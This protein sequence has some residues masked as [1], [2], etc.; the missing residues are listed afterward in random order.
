M[1]TDLQPDAGTSTFRYRGRFI[2]TESLV[3]LGALAGTWQLVTQTGTPPISDLKPLG[4]TTW[5]LPGLWLLVSV[6]V[7]SSIAAAAAWRRSAGTPVAVL[8][9]SGAL[10]VEL[11][12]Q[13]PFVGLSYFQLIF[14]TIAAAMAF[15]AVRARRSG[16]W[17]QVRVGRG[18]ARA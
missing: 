10:V 5:T 16:S 18:Q 9:A 6:A 1:T 8:I 7:P 3:A 2:A 17:N 15:L 12:V 13:M 14:G 11:V 4:L